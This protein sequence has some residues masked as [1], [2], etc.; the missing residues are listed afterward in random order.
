MRVRTTLPSSGALLAKAGIDAG[1]AFVCGS[2]GFVEMAS[3]L[4]LEG[5]YEPH[6]IRTERFGPQLS[7][8]ESQ[9][10]QAKR[11]S[12]PRTRTK[13]ESVWPLTSQLAPSRPDTRPAVALKPQTG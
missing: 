5:G 9:R 3:Q 1:T 4:L 11:A 12:E 13:P 10:A 7:L 6:R 8:C 2:N